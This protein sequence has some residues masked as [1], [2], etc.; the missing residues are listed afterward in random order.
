[1]E[2]CLKVVKEEL[3]SKKKKDVWELTELPNEK[4]KKRSFDINGSSK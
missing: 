4:R 3:D 2:Q 1:M